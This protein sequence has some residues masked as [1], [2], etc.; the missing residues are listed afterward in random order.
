MARI[1]I[2]D[3]PKKRIVNRNELKK[4][5]GG[6]TSVKDPHDRYTN[7][8]TSY[9]LQRMEQYEKITMLTS[10]LIKKT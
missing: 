6:T 9:L 3:L 5:F 2:R 1:K 10:N 8:E 7:T 4:V